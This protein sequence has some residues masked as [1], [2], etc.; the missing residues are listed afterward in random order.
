M[1]VNN[2]ER[3]HF[4]GDAWCGSTPLKDKYPLLYNLRN[5]IDI[6]VAEAAE[7]IGSSLIE[8]GFLLIFWYKMVK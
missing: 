5:E 2:G 6:T 7:E 3:T 1:K 8:D 4:L